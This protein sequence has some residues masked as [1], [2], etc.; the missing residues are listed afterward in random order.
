LQTQ[1]PVLECRANVRHELG[2]PPDIQM[3]VGVDRLDYTKG[4]LERFYAVERL[5]ELE[6]HLRGKFTLV[7]IAAP[8]RSRIEQYQQFD[9]HVRAEAHRINQKFANGGFPPICLK[10]EHHGPEKVYEYFRAADVCVVTSLHDGMNLVAKEFV[11][12]RD[13]EQGVLFL[14]QFP[15]AARELP[16]SLIAQEATEPGRAYVVRRYCGLWG[17]GT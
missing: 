3:A 11:A 6:P 9:A 2:M 5:M 12:A 14:S 7:Q 16:E 1:K 10:L 13:D 8:S 4:I 17:R 15:G